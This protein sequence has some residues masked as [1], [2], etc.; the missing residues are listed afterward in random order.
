RASIRRTLALYRLGLN[1]EGLR[2]WQYALRAANDQ[3][4]L[5][6]AAVAQA[7]D[8]PDRAISAAERTQALHDLSQR[9]PTPYR[10]Q[11]QT[12]AQNY[13][14]DESWVYGLIRQE[15]RFKADIQS[16]AGAI[17]LMQLMP[18]TARWAAKQAG[19]KDF[20]LTNTT[21]VATNLELGSYYLRHVLDSLGH[22]VLATAAYNAGP[23]RA[24][25][26]KAQQPLEGAIYAET[27]PFNETR[28]YV[29]KVMTNAWFYAYRLGG[30]N[31]SLKNIMG[32]VPGKSAGID[33]ADSGASVLPAPATP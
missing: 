21:H 19:I 23:S 26:W 4:L 32:T 7:A 16:R 18:T 20:S 13:R 6:A 30:A 10:H 5:A 29:K 12:S 31:I 3:E 14:L 9:F 25:R 28:D 24:K 1:N 2:E 27:I 22:P 11:L 17:G 15:S 8:L 33:L